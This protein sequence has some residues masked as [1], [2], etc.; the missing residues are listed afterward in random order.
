[1]PTE[2]ILDQE[3]LS[4]LPTPIIPSA[5]SPTN[6]AV[7]ALFHD[8]HIS[9]R[10]SPVTA[11]FL[12][13]L[14]HPD[15]TQRLGCGPRGY[16]D[17]RDHEFFADISW[18]DFE[19]KKVPPP[20]VPDTSVANCDTEHELR[21]QLLDEKP[22]KIK[23]EQQKYFIGWDYK[24]ELGKGRGDSLNG[25]KTVVGGQMSGLSEADLEM[26]R[27]V[28]D[29]DDVGAVSGGG[30]GKNIIDSAEIRNDGKKLDNSI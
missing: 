27:R 25:E 7:H 28:N 22:K 26:R 9:S 24:C 21:Q 5:N 12:R 18:D 6:N 4:P 30:G 2:N 13:A 15:R 11:N 1:M 20:F 14:L 3:Q 29:T 10:I 19:Q 16:L 8:L 23:E 17:I